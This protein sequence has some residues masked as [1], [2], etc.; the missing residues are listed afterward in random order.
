MRKQLSNDKIIEATLQLIANKGS[1]SNVNFREVARFLGCAHTSLY[2][3]YPNYQE[4]LLASAQALIHQMRKTLM[5][6]FESLESFMNAEDELSAYAKWI[7]E[8]AFTHPGWY[9]FLWMDYLEAAPERVLQGQ[10]GAEALLLDVF[11]SHHHDKYTY[12]E[13]SR[14][15]QVGHSYVH[16]ELCKWLAGRSSYSHPDLLKKAILSHMKWLCQK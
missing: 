16:G 4:L 12:E 11:M 5:L 13:A 8:Y 6:S 2:N 9:R 1:A 3:F 10:P 14:I 7:Y 15:L